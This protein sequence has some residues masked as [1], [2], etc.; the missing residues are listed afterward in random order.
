MLL[1]LVHASLL[2]LLGC[3]STL[4][5]PAGETGTPAP[6]APSRA[7]SETPYLGSE[8]PTDSQ[9]CGAQGKYAPSCGALWGVYTL[10]GSDPV[11]ALRA[12]ERKVGR[13]FDVTQRFHDFSD[14]VHLGQFPD[15]YEQVVGSD[16]ILFLSWQA[17]VTTTGQS[18]AW[19]DIAD[20]LYDQA[21]VLPAAQRLKAWG[22]PVIVA[23]DPEF[24]N[25][26]RGTMSDYVAAYRHVHDVFASQ[27]VTNVA[28]AWV[29]T[30]YLGA[31][32]GNRIRR[33][34]PGDQYVDWVGYDPYNFY[35]CNSSEWKSFEETIAPMYEWLTTMGM[36]DKP[37]LLSEYGTQ[38]DPDDSERSQQWHTSIPSVLRRYPNLKALIRFDAVGRFGSSKC[39]LQIDNGSGMLES[40]AG[41]GR[42]PYLTRERD[43]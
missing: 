35:R 40:F 13:T 36:D 11:A 38:Y 25:Q 31:D 28:W 4:S 21:Q 37:F 42:D 24:D 27:G 2:V 1:V 17:R 43:Y 5:T 19:R 23:F 41:A 34:Y 6:A 9:S 39:Y 18:L 8:T 16:R 29:S 7:I 32:N 33:G 22:R 10:A 30:G 3:S 20:G 14:H 26:D 12:L 15:R